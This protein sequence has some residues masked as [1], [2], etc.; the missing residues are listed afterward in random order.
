ME[1]FSHGTLSRLCDCGCNS[2]N[3]ELDDGA[4]VAPLG[5]PSNRG[6]VAFLLAFETEEP[7][8][9][10]EFMIYVDAKG[11]LDGMDV[12]FMGNTSPVPDS[13]SIVEPPYHVYGPLARQA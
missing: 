3:F 13:F 10:I 11:D 7:K 9:T 6:G 4:D 2:Y 5:P 12:D 1:Q 8:G